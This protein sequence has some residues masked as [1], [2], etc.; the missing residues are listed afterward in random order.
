MYRKRANKVY[1]KKVFSHTAAKVHPKNTIKPPT[2]GG[3]RL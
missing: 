1:D 3:Y 2:R